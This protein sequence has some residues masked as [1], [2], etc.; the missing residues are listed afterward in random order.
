MANSRSALKRVRQ[1]KTRTLRN[2]ALKSEVKSLRKDALAAIEA[3]DSKKA[4]ESYNQFASATDKAA[5]RGAFHKKT[6][7]RLKS[8]VATKINAIGS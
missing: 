1:T 2:R 4:Q 8:R 3:G 6:A 5:K 7:S